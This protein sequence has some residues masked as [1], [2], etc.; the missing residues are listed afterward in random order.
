MSRNTSAAAHARFVNAAIPALDGVRVL[1][2]LIVLVHNV[3]TIQEL[4]MT[5]P[6]KLV[7]SVTTAGWTGV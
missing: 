5:V 2:I 4:G 7:S 6:R 3:S 1:A